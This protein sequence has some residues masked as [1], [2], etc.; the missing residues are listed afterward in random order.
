MKNSLNKN[1][2][3]SSVVV[4]FG[5]S[6]GIGL[7]I[8]ELLKNN[9]WIVILADLDTP[10]IEVTKKFDFFKVDI[11]NTEQLNKLFIYIEKK[12]RCLDGLVNAA[13]YNSHSSVV[14]LDDKKME[15]LLNVHLSGVVRSSRV[16][17]DLLKNNNSS[18]VNFSSIG[19]RIGRP[20]RAIYAAAKAGV[21]AFTRTLSIEWANDNIRVNCVVPGIIN[22]RMVSQN[23]KDGLVDVESLINSIPLKRFGD[24]NEVAEAV[25][26]LLS[27]KASYITGQSIVVDGGVLA[28]GNW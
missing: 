22:T 28:N 16:F 10:G 14:E 1:N 8:G 11:T 21:E 20:R 12:Y 27:K 18:I 26:F 2:K 4:V 25:M 24:P 3:K 7:A 13:G 5:G 23:I 6:R 19:A 9:K 15:D 17:Y